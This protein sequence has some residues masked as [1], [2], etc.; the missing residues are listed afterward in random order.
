[1]VHL[2]WSVVVTR[3]RLLRVAC[4]LLWSNNNPNMYIFPPPRLDFIVAALALISFC[5]AC[6]DS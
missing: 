3:N 5:I 6:I 2:L 4:V 1:M